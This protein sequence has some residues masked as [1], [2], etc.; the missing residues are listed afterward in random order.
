MWGGGGLFCRDCSTVLSRK[1]FAS[2]ISP[3][4]LGLCSMGSDWL[5]ESVCKPMARDGCRAR[6][7]DNKMCPEFC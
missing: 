7:P 1:Q 3:K 6:V 2:L 4:A 5:A